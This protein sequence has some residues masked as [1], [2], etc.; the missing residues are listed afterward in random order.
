MKREFFLFAAMMVS[1]TVFSQSATETTVKYNKMDVPGVSFVTSDYNVKVTAEAL[2]ARLEKDA[3]L[4]GSNANGFRFYQAQPFAEFGSLNYDIYVKVATTGKK[5]D[6]KTVIY[7]LV[8]KGNENFESG[9]KDIEL[10]ENVKTF[11]NNFVATYLRQYDI[12]MKIQ[13]QA[14]LIKKLEKENKS[15]LSSRDKLKKQTEENERA[16]TKNQNDLQKAK[17]DLN[18]LK[19][20]K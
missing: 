4:K 9:A 18:T 13:S 5:K 2:K 19:N 6:L 7:L 11:L 8:S 16:I 20:S 17:G 3:R 10:I 14:K 12:E 1:V 15:L